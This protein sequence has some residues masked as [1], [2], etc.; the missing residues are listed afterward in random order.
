MENTYSIVDLNG[1]ATAIRQGAAESLSEKYNE[2]LDEFISINQV[3]NLV[4][5]HSLGTDENNDHIINEDIFDNIFDEVRD[6][7]YSIGISKL[8]ASGSIE[9]A[10]DDDSNEMVFWISDKNKQRTSKK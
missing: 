7:I 2:N 3:I 5:S 9:C 4:K 6:W 8:A 10:W 1:F